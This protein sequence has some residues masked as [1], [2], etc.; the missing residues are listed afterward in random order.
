MIPASTTVFT[1]RCITTTIIMATITTTIMI[2]ARAMATTTRRVMTIET[3]GMSR[4]SR[5]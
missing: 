4:G 1:A 3:S 2:M 5:H